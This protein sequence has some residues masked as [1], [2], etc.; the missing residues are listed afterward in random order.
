MPPGVRQL[1]N[2]QGTGKPMQPAVPPVC[3]PL[4]STKRD[5]CASGAVPSENK[6]VRSTVQPH[7]LRQQN[8]QDTKACGVSPPCGYS[9]TVNARCFAGPAG[10]LFSDFTVLFFRL[11]LRKCVPAALRLWVRLR[12]RPRECALPRPFCGL[13]GKAAVFRRQYLPIPGVF[14]HAEAAYPC[15]AARCDWSVK[16]HVTNYRFPSEFHL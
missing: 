4:H 5:R 15:R 16:L 2:R 3:Y 9:R 8:L 13:S 1:Q 12:A 14:V 10:S 11:F 6:S 7:S